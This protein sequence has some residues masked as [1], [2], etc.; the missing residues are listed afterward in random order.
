M[1]DAKYRA[2]LVNRDIAERRA[3]RRAGV[4]RVGAA[5]VRNGRRSSR[6]ENA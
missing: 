2:P 3:T 6:L 5:Y 1:N 4:T